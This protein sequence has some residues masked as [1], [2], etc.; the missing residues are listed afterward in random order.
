MGLLIDHPLPGGS[1]T[2]NDGNTARK[3]FENWQIT[4]EILNL[5]SNLIFKFSI[6]LRTISGHYFLNYSKFSNYTRET[7]ELYVK[8][9][10]WYPMP[11][12]VHKLLV[13]GSMIASNM[14]VSLGMMSEEA[15]VATKI[16][17]IID[18]TMPVNS[19]DMPQI[20]I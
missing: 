12:A 2:S 11:N 14:S 4:S 9:Y 6:I 1:G 7:A 13:H 18:S 3:F 20:L 17:K 15:Q 16:S 5:N 19:A 8:E 10:H